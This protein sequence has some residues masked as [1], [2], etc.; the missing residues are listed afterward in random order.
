M[1][2][3]SLKLA[4]KRTPFGDVSNT[5]NAL[6]DIGP[7]D[8]LKTR[9]ASHLNDKENAARLSDGLGR[10][11]VRPHSM[12]EKDYGAAVSMMP[13]NLIAKPGPLSRATELPVP[14]VKN[15]VPKRATIVFN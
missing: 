8:L 9:V 7:H 1:N 3:G 4:P 12:V 15:V 13:P 14:V 11:T 6:V 5:A 2:Y 10:P